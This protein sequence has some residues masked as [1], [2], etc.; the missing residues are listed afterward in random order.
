MPVR[1]IA[2]RP[3]C[4]ERYVLDV[5]LMPTGRPHRRFK[6][7]RKL[8]WNSR[9]EYHYV[10]FKGRE[11]PVFESTDSVRPFIHVKPCVVR[12]VYGNERYLWD[13]KEFRVTPRKMYQPEKRLPTMRYP[14]TIAGFMTADS[15]NMWQGNMWGVLKNGTRVLLK[16][17]YN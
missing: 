14:A 2:V 8:R 3:D 15:V 16:S 9:K 5:I 10:V 13:F 12:D 7:V 11:H 17:V 4:S 1:K 6:I